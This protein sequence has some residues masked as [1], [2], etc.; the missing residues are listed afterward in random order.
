MYIDNETLIREIKGLDYSTAEK[1][2][3][4]RAS[5][6]KIKKDRQCIR[7]KTEIKAGSNAITASHM[8][9]K[10]YGIE[11]KEILI[12]NYV[13]EDKFSFV[14]V[15]HWVCTD[16]ASDIVDKNRKIRM[17]SI[18]RRLHKR[19]SK[20]TLETLYKRGEITAKEWD[21]IEMA[22]IHNYAFEEAVGLGQE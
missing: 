16:C 12:N 1:N 18:H 6:V 19:S 13:D 5:L 7:C 22:E 20:D 2:D 4:A 14:P 3:L 11:L 8:T 10:R 15:R 9:D 21:D 17:N